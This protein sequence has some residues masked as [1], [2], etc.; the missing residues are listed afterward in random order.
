MTSRRDFIRQGAL[1]VAGAALIE[2]KRLW[3]FPVNPAA[4]NARTT[5]WGFMG[6]ENGWPVRWI[7]F[8]D[9]S[10]WVVRDGWT[11]IVEGPK[12]SFVL[13]DKRVLLGTFRVRP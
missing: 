3:A 8:D 6:L 2:P 10:T 12:E 1:W 9:G 11:R 13:P 7:E 5:A 4:R